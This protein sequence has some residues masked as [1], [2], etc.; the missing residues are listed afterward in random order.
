M[1]Q[2]GYRVVVLEKKP[3]EQVG[4]AIDIFHMDEV[5]FDQ[6]GLPHPSGE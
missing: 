2:A 5:R 3:L 1:A 6:F 4:Q